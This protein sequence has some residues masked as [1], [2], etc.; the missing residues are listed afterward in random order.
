MQK[1]K[2]KMQNLGGSPSNQW[3][4]TINHIVRAGSTRLRHGLRNGQGTT[5]LFVDSFK[6]CPDVSSHI[7]KEAGIPIT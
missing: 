4:R 6:I 7:K 2:C 1:S 5:I 3:C